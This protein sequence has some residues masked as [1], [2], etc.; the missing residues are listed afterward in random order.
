LGKR[1]TFVCIEI[2]TWVI[3]KDGTRK[4]GQKGEDGM[5]RERGVGGY[6]FLGPIYVL[7]CSLVVVVEGACVSDYRGIGVCRVGIV[8]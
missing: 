2:G 6:M 8:E 5:K 4:G 7:G 3:Y 1:V